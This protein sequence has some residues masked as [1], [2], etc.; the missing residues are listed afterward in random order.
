MINWRTIFYRIPG[1]NAVSVRA[2][3]TKNPRAQAPALAYEPGGRRFESCRA[4]HPPP[5]A[6]LCMRATARWLIRSAPKFV[7]DRLRTKA[8]RARQNTKKNESKLR[9]LVASVK[10]ASVGSQDSLE[11]PRGDSVTSRI[12]LRHR[13]I[14]TRTEQ[15]RMRCQSR[16]QARSRRLSSGCLDGDPSPRRGLPIAAIGSQLQSAVR[17][18]S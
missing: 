10:G 7:A 9:A 14:V 4:R 8:G 1:I 16:S 5:L 6:F 11:M 15:T 13:A 3:D 2:T 12:R 18:S 17:P